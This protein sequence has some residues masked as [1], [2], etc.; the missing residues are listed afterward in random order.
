MLTSKN[1]IK[2]QLSKGTYTISIKGKY[3][4]WLCKSINLISEEEFLKKANELFFE[5]YNKEWL[6]S[7][8]N[9][10]RLT[11]YDRLITNRWASIN[12]R[13]ING[14]YNSSESV[15]RCEQMKSYHKKQITIDITFE[16][17][18]NWMLDNEDLHNEIVESGN[19]S[20]ID[21]IDE[22]KGYS[23][24]NMR[25]ISLHENIENRYGKECEYQP[26]EEKTKKKTQNQKNYKN[27]KMNQVE[28]DGIVFKN[29]KELAKYLKLP[30]QTLTNWLRTGKIQINTLNKENKFPKQEKERKYCN[31]GL[32]Y[33]GKMFRTQTE[34]AQYLGI[35]NSKLSE[36]IK[37]KKIMVIR[38]K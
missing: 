9:E 5:K 2:S 3:K 31:K 30:Y 32:E 24:D 18:R 16:E 25:L 22:T 10:K 17:F 29:K 33:Q 35:S 26:N 1:I 11:N 36:R 14:K 28:Y 20:S 4:F 7:C 6:G 34:L 37:E 27:I 23:L 21:R 12:Q 15:Q 13:T 19:K 38:H 8:R